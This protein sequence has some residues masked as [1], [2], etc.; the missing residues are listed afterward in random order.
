MLA[1]SSEYGLLSTNPTVWLSDQEP[2]QAFQKGL[3]PE[4]A[5]LKQWWTYLSQCK[6]TIR[7]IQGI[8]NELA[9]Y[10]SR[11]NAAALL[12]QTSEALAKE[13][14]QRMEVELE[15]PWALQVSSRVGVCSPAATRSQ[16]KRL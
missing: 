4:K 2:V 12:A 3:P 9:D 7:H 11:N 13:A 10:I 15:C 1:L 5:K 16:G 14:F 8:N 6:L